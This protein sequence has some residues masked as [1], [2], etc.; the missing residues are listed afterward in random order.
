[1]E[2]EVIF[3]H[4]S[5]FGKIELMEKNYI[6]DIPID[7]IT[8]KDVLLRV[9]EAF[10]G[11][12]DPLVIFYGNAETLLL[13]SR[14]SAYHQLL[15]NADI[16][17]PDGIGL[18]LVGRLTGKQFRERVAGSDLM[19]E[20]CVLA[21]HNE[22]SVFLLGGR[23]DVAKRAS[24][25]LKE[26]IPLLRVDGYKD[27]YSNSFTALDEDTSADIVFVGLG[28]PLQERWIFENM[29]TFPKAKIFM[30][31][32]GAF[33][34]ISGGLKRAPSLFQK[35]GIEWLWRFFLEPRK[36]FL[37]ITNAVLVFPARAI[38]D[39]LHSKEKQTK[40]S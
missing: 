11:A 1:L 5:I 23:N 26:K 13:A 25:M 6:F 38:W 29:H 30:A 31:V 28:A 33:D 21:S 8:H 3:Y 10:H 34:M 36:R 17:F 15:K 16:V 14:D 32:G 37:R 22:K 7:N 19:H 20:I 4:T 12:G 27:G 9:E 35:L 40:L 18:S 39:I 24:L 2:G